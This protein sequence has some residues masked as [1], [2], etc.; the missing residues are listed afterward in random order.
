MPEH[1]PC[2]ANG[3]IWCAAAAPGTAG[4]YGGRPSGIADLPVD[5]V[6]AP[7]VVRDDID[8]Q[9]VEEEPEIGDGRAEMMAHEAVGAVAADD[10]APM[11]LTS[12]V[13][14]RNRHRRALVVRPKIDHLAAAMNCNRWKRPG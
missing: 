1:M 7:A 13:G 3:G 9:P 6:P 10:P 11:D 4:H 2:P 14:A 12:A 5:R 8:D